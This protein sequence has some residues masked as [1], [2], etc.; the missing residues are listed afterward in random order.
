MTG[1]LPNPAPHPPGG[2]DGAQLVLPVGAERIATRR[3]LPGT[4]RKLST[5]APLAAGYGAFQAVLSSL[6][7]SLSSADVQYLFAV[8][9]G[10]AAGAVTGCA[11]L[12]I[13]R[14]QPKPVRPPSATQSGV[15]PGTDLMTML[16]SCHQTFLGT[17]VTFDDPDL[18][19]LTGWPHFLHEA[20]DRLRP[21]A[22]GTAYGLK[23]AMLMGDQDGRL[24]RAALTDTLW[25]LRRI[26]E[27]DGGERPVWMSYQG[28]SAL[29]GC[30]LRRWSP[31]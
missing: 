1:Q 4:L 21:T 18:G 2:P 29:Q 30:A 19:E 13:R 9:C 15:T 7:P 24:N 17:V 5:I 8:A 27:W 12:L 31:S 20:A 26:W 28:I 11:V 22:Y 16:R 10:V 23:L 25:K 3:Q 6:P 14:T